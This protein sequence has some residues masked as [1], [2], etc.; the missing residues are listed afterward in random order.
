[1]KAYCLVFAQH[2]YLLQAVTTL[3]PKSIEFWNAS[4]SGIVQLAPC[5]PELCNL[6]VQKD[7]HKTGGG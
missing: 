5:I 1:M 3:Q 6:T 4:I 7:K 2:R